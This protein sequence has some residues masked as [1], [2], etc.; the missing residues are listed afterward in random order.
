MFDQIMM[1][2]EEDIQ[3]MEVGETLVVNCMIHQWM[4]NRSF[5]LVKTFL[6]SVSKLWPRLVVLVEEELFNFSRLK[7]MS[8]VEFFYKALHH[9]TAVCDSLGSNVWVATIFFLQLLHTG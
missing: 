4:L 2:R 5:S 6:D 8:P 1:E 7:L 3:G 9:Y